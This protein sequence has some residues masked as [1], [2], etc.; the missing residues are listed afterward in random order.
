MKLQRHEYGIGLLPT[1]SGFDN[2]I[3]ISKTAL[4][5]WLAYYHEEVEEFRKK[6][7][8][9]MVLMYDSRAGLLEDILEHFE[10]D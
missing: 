7:Q 6:G 1:K 8:W 4:E 9:D 10:K 3:T 5:N 2:G